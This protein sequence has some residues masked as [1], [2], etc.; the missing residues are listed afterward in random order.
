[1]PTSSPV[2][3]VS[4]A[5]APTESPS[6]QATA[7]QIGAPAPTTFVVTAAPNAVPETAAPPLPQEEET[8]PDRR[9]PEL[10]IS[11]DIVPNSEQEFFPES[12][13]RQCRGVAV[14]AAIVLAVY[15]S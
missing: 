1:M 3:A 13:A 14:M 7:A 11:Q 6:I 9:A 12:D 4:I 10:I 2:L 5:A 8:A 15:I